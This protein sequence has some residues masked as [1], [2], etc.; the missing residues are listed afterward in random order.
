MLG[1]EIELDYYVFFAESDKGWVHSD[2]L[3]HA[4]RPNAPVMAR[5]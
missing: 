2:H 1:R 4:P 3:L 5:P